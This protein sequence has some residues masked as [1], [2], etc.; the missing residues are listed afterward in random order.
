MKKVKR[1]LLLLMLTVFM[2]GSSSLTVFAGN[3]A[4]DVAGNAGQ[5]AEQM[6]VSTGSVS[7]TSAYTTLGNLIVAGKDSASSGVNVIETTKKYTAN[8]GGYVMY[9]SLVSASS[10]TTGF[11]VEGNFELLTSSAKREFLS[12]LFDLTQKIKSANSNVTNETL[13]TWN[14]CVQTCNGVDA[15]LIAVLMQGTKPDFISAMQ[16]YAPFQSP[17]STVLGV[18][19]LILFSALTISTLIDL[20]FIGIPPVNMFLMGDGKDKPGIVS[21]AAYNAYLTESGGAGGGGGQG[22]KSSFKSAAGIYFK[23]RVIMLILMFVCILYLV[24]GEVWNLLAD[25]ISLFEGLT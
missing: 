2:V 22:G 12:D 8:G 1:V 4:S 18:F 11:I 13:T 6:S 14:Q 5:T 24:S 17:I 19:S 16:I 21:A 15:Q 9:S 23:H 25:A 10:P 7:S 3:P 20:F